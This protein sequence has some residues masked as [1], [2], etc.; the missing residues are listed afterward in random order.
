MTMRLL[1][2]ASAVSRSIWPR[3]WV[4]SA[5]VLASEKVALAPPAIEAVTEKAPAVVPAVTVICARPLELV[6]AGAAP[7]AETAPAAGA[8]AAASSTTGAEAAA[9]AAVGGVIDRGSP[10]GRFVVGRL[11]Q[12]LNTS[13]GWG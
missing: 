4:A 8:A 6:A 2:W 10:T 7:G 3:M 9:A 1:A 5:A 13:S 11:D 12:R